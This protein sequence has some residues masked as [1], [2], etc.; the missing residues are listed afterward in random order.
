MRYSFSKNPAWVDK[1]G[2]TEGPMLQEGLRRI[3]IKGF[4]WA[5]VPITLF[6]NAFRHVWA[7]DKQ[8]RESEKSKSQDNN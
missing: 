4:L 6:G 5:L 2:A 8:M 7:V 1:L 3:K